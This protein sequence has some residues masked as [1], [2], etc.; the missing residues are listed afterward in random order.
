M[1]ETEI[2][3][4]NDAVKEKLVQFGIT[5][6][7]QVAKIKQLGAESVD[8]LAHLTEEDFHQIGVPRL[9]A[10]KILASLKSQAQA[11]IDPNIS[12][13]TASIN[14][15]NILP[16]IPDDESWL[17]SLCASGV[18]KPEQSTII[19]A[20]RA[21][22]ADKFGLYS[23]PPRLVDA[24]EEYTNITEEPVSEEFWKLRKQ[25]TRRSYGDLF[26]AIDGL[27]GTYVTEGRK[28]EL[29]QRID[30]ILWPAIKTFMDSL[31]GWQQTWMQG[32]A[33]PAMMLAMVAGGSNGLPPGMMQ[34]PDCGAL[35]DAAAAV[36][37][38]LNRVFR[39]TAVQIT[40]ALA[41]EANQ[42]KKMLENSRL[43]ML[44][45]QPNREMLLKK[46]DINVP[47]IYPRMEANLTRFVLS[48]IQ[49]NNV[50]TAEELSYFGTLYMLGNQI[51]WNDIGD[52]TSIKKSHANYG[53][54][55]KRNDPFVDGAGVS[56]RR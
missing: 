4:V 10:R 44:C 7:D 26:S 49:I 18:L 48:I 47:L 31:N 35:R 42:I 9:K 13:A 2:V 36:N 23:I 22:L 56:A 27:D 15:N 54:G 43:P 30:E 3:E 28:K 34:P 8:D 11:Q 16:T 51:P 32:A 6:D 29:L 14:I 37:A 12:A 45:G 24:M 21:C 55:T 5:S 25:L 53:I 38:A 46:L 1:S 33:N 52:N 39:G 17:S 19:S 40:A 20:I 41:Y 50:G